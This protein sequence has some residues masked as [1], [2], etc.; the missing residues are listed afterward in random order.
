[1]IPNK[2]AS[3]TIKHTNVFLT[4]SWP[5]LLLTMLP[6]C[7]C[8]W[9]RHLPNNLQLCILLHYYITIPNQRLNRGNIRPGSRMGKLRGV[10]LLYRTSVWTLLPINPA[11][12]VVVVVRWG[13][14]SG[15]AI[16]YILYIWGGRRKAVTYFTV[17]KTLAWHIVVWNSFI[18]YRRHPPEVSQQSRTGGALPTYR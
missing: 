3:N 15:S 10:S 18:I 16:N 2:V 5:P 12:L 7:C 13:K 8:F 1:M 17:T 6:S 11:S 14:Q 9:I 4:R